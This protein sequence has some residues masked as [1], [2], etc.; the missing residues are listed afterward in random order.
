M[1][2]DWKVIALVAAVIL[3]PACSVGTVQAVE[4]LSVPLIYTDPLTGCQYVTAN[5][6]SGGGG[7]YPR[8]DRDGKQVCLDQD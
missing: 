2:T 8:M 4:R 3:A 1:K 6:V 5:Q 7:I